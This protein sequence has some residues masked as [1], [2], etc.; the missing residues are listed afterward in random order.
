MK[1]LILKITSLLTILTIIL[2]G[3][4]GQKNSKVKTFD[5]D[6]L[7]NM[8]NQDTSNFNLYLVRGEKYME[9]KEFK[10]AKID[11]ERVLK[12]NDTCL[13]CYYQIG[14]IYY[15]QKKY[16]KAISYFYE[17]ERLNNNE[18]NIYTYLIS[19]FCYLN[20]MDSVKKFSRVAYSHN[21]N[22][23]IIDMCYSLSFYY[24]GRNPNIKKAV[25]IINKTENIEKLDYEDSLAFFKYR[26]LVN[27]DVGNYKK[28]LADL[29]VI[30]NKQQVENLEPYFIYLLVQCY[31][32]QNKIGLAR[33][34]FKYLK[35]YSNYEISIFKKIFF[36][37]FNY[38]DLKK[39]LYN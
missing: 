34:Y 3:C 33:Y 1:F 2:F 24:N 38:D 8:I 27:Y 18:T 12:H 37:T 14:R 13:I 6:N 25:E 4:E 23:P 19:T 30:I 36:V 17:A 28:T 11:F 7:T 10:L 22:Y 35:K 9:N 26:S 16:S 29:N 32:K 31:Y 39:Q 15:D 21:I 5:I 20:A